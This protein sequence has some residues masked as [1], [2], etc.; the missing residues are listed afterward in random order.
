MNRRVEPGPEVWA[1][2]RL[3]VSE[4][5]IEGSG[6]FFTEDVSRGTV[7]IRLGGRLVSSA[8]LDRLIRGRSRCRHRCTSTRS[9]CTRT[10]TWCC[11]QQCR[12]TSAITVAI[13]T[14]GSSDLTNLPCVALR[15]Q[16]MRQ[17][18]TTGHSPVLRALQWTVVVAW[19][20]AEA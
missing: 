9:P 20:T 19:S 8:E 11:R 4:S 17:P 3:N 10:P 2:E 1:D 7:I 18:L 14:C 15:L 13:P 16:V 6:L 12:F 5:P